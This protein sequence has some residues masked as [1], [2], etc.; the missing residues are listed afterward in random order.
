RCTDLVSYMFNDF[1]PKH[2]VNGVVLSG[3][4]QTSDIPR[5][6]SAVKK[7]RPYTD[8][9]VVLGPIVEYDRALPRLLAQAMYDGD[10]G[11]P[12]RHHREGPRDVDQAMRQALA[13]SGATYVSLYDAVCPKGACTL[14]TADNN[15][16]QFDYGHMTAEGSRLILSR[17]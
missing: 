1:L 10:N 9:L 5:L 11:L 12:S 15:P 6:L 8:K 14:W 16:L 17:V 3:R 4:W 2:H 13:T 7:L